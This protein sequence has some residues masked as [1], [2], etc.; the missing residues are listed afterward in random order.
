MDI[1]ETFLIQLEI[2]NILKIKNGFFLVNL[3][4]GKITEPGQPLLT[5]CI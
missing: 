5:L 2:Y 3:S 4:I 1:I